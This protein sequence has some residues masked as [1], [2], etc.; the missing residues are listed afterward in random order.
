MFNVSIIEI[1]IRISYKD[2]RRIESCLKRVIE[3][4]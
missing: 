1:V 3:E 2:R 4:S